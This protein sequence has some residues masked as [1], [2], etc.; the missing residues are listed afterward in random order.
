MKN[1]TCELA[2]YQD[3][4]YIKYKFHSD[5]P[6]IVNNANYA[7]FDT[8][9]DAFKKTTES[10]GGFFANMTSRMLLEIKEECNTEITTL[11]MVCIPTKHIDPKFYFL[12]LDKDDNIIKQFMDDNIFDYDYFRRKLIKCMTKEGLVY[13]LMNNEKFKAITDEMARDAELTTDLCI[14]GR[15]ATLDDTIICNSLEILKGDYQTNLKQLGAKGLE[16]QF[17]SGILN[18]LYLQA[19]IFDENHEFLKQFQVDSGIKDIDTYIE[20]MKKE[21][22]E[23]YS[24]KNVET[25]D[26]TVNIPIHYAQHI[27]NLLSYKDKPH[28]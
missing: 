28:T 15:H 9:S 26:E 2:S 7:R 6:I 25:D 14:N 23:K 16:F 20:M 22:G 24:E 10:V 18:A 19:R 17:Q 21:Y 27:V 8:T 12:Y 1:L 3:K 11:M 4:S 13:E 5:N